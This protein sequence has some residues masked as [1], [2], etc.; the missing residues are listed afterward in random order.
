MLYNENS[1]GIRTDINEHW[2]QDIDIDSP[3]RPAGILAR[4]SI[5]SCSKQFK[6]ISDELRISIRF[7]A[8]EQ[9]NVEVYMQKLPHLQRLTIDFN[10][11]TDSIRSSLKALHQILPKLKVLFLNCNEGSSSE[12]SSSLSSSATTAVERDAS[13][14]LTETDTLAH[15]LIPWS[16][17]LQR[18]EIFNLESRSSTS[19]TCSVMLGC[20]SQ[21]V[22]LE[23]LNVQSSE[24]LQTANIAGCTS[25]LKLTLFGQHMYRLN[26]THGFN[27][28]VTS[29]TLL[30]ELSCR[31]CS[32]EHINVFGLT[33]LRL[34][35][36][37]GNTV[38][39]LDLSS[40]TSVTS[41]DCNSNRLQ[42]LDMT[43]CPKLETLHCGSNPLTKLLLSGCSHLSTLGCASVNLDFGE[44]DLSKCT[45][46]RSLHLAEME[47]LLNL[48]LRDCP[49]LEDLSLEGTSDVET[50]N[51][52]GL[53][54]LYKVRVDWV[55]A[56]VID[57]TGCT[58]LKL[59]VCRA[60]SNL[61]MLSLLGCSK[62]HSL[63][64]HSC[65]LRD[66]DLSSCKQLG[67]LD[68]T[69]TPLEALDLT[70]CVALETISCSRSVLKSLDVSPSAA[71]LEHLDCNNCPL[72]EVLH[73]TNCSVLK[74]LYCYNCPQL[75]ELRCKGCSSLTKLSCAGCGEFSDQSGTL[76]LA[77][78]G[79]V[80]ES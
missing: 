51:L 78:T 76:L 11:K 65:G 56:A 55:A 16:G 43:P 53:K 50:I 45:A 3:M 20:L 5:R 68:C 62:L 72:L 35:D 34:V 75:Q 32:L 64:V 18:L 38:S 17:S 49:H 52:A 69:I 19:Q 67:H 40:C 66:I 79:K 14:S 48:D 70:S 12:A 73:A 10:T 9:C 57:L 59:L 61:T 25:L 30:Q 31:H 27:L 22:S 77:A 6:S 8:G 47:G 33:A 7:S 15:H 29:C 36:L 24:I 80:G 74:F 42:V 23:V 58:A 63:M 26:G 37:S 21:L 39:E 2:L 60:C 1:T 46:L 54:E 71:T 13:N 44:F 41:L 4:Q 28:D